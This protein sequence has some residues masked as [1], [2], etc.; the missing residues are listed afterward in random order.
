MYILG[1]DNVWADLLGHWA[2]PS[3]F[4]RLVSIP[5]IP[6]TDT[7]DFVWPTKISTFEVQKGHEPSRAPTTRFSTAFGV[8][9]R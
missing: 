1:E 5:V 2:A 8:P 7:E 4:R 3:I 6:S 9:E